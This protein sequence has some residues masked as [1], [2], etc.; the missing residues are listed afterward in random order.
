VRAAIITFEVCS[1]IRP[2]GGATPEA[3]ASNSGALTLCGAFVSH[4][5]PARPPTAATVS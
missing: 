2:R 5:V 3:N 1:L 4:G